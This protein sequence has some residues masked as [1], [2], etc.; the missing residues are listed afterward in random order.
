MNSL[1]TM[2]VFFDKKGDIKA[3]T[4]TPDSMFESFQS[5]N[6]PLS[7]VEE[8]LSGKKSSFNYHVKPATQL[9]TGG[10]KLIK[11]TNNVI[12]TRSL[13]AYLTR[14]N[15][16]GP[17]PILLI[18]TDLITNTISLDLNT[19]YKE[20][21]NEDAESNKDIFSGTTPVFLYIT[22][23]NNPYHLLHTVSFVPETLLGEMH[24]EFPYDPGIDLSTSS[25][26]T[27]KL[28]SSYGYK[29]KG[30]RHDI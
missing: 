1:I 7:E 14:V 4:P 30:K 5:A 26:Y 8:F 18:T 24:M 13:D 17:W 15:T 28:I 21:F 25:V 10:Y 2:Y 11:K 9:G 20:E 6:F 22:K 23:K 19:D 16:S 27:K 29:I 12:I 3:I